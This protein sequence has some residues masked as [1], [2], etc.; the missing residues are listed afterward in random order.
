METLKLRILIKQVE[1]AEI[2]YLY[3]REAFDLLKI[4]K[5]TYDDSQ[6]VEVGTKIEYEGR[7]LVVDSVNLKMYTETHEMD[8]GYGIN[9]YSPTEQAD[10]NCQLHVFVKDLK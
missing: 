10:Y 4:E 1:G 8:H 6:F 9:L 2:A 7:K 3:S 5:Q